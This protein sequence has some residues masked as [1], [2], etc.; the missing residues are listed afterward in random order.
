MAMLIFKY[1]M[2]QVDEDHQKNLKPC[3]KLTQQNRTWMTA[4]QKI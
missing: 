2:N 1:E 4:H 3:F